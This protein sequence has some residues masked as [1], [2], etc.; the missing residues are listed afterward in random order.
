MQPNVAKRQNR[1]GKGNEWI[2]EVEFELV[3]PV[4]VANEALVGKLG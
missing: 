4:V 3:A 2:V 1:A